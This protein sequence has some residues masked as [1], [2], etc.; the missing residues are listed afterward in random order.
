MYFGGGT[1]SYLGTKR[2]VKILKTILKKYKVDK[3]A[4][5]YKRQGGL[6]AAASPPETA[7]H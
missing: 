4:D 1:P 3:Q 5:V 2:L 6:P 7:A